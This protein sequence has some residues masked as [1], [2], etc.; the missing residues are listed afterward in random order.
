MPPPSLSHPSTPE[1]RYPQTK[2]RGLMATV[3]LTAWPLDYLEHGAGPAVVMQ[4]AVMT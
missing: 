4:H 1:Q 3:A 2:Q